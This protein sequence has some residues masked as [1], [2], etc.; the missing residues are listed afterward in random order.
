MTSYNGATPSWSGYTHQGKVGLITAL[1]EIEAL[2]DRTDSDHLAEE[3]SKWLLA[4]EGAEDFEITNDSDVVWSRHQVKAYPESM[5]QK[6]YNKVLL[7]HKNKA[8]DSVEGFDITNVRDGECYLHTVVAIN[9]WQDEGDTNPQKIKLYTYGTGDKYCDFSK[10]GDYDKLESLYQPL[11]KKIF[12]NANDNEIKG[13]W[14]SLGYVLDEHITEGHI[15]R[16]RPE[17][18]FYEIYEF[19]LSDNPLTKNTYHYLKLQIVGCWEERMRRKAQT[20]ALDTP[21]IERAR[22][23]FDNFCSLDQKSFFKAISIMHP[24]HLG[25]NRVDQIGID[26]VVY[27]GIEKINKDIDVNSMQ[28]VSDEKYILTA[29][30][31]DADHA[32]VYAEDICRK[33]IENPDITEQLFQNGNLITRHIEGSFHDLLAN[34]TQGNPLYSTSTLGGESVDH[35]M[36]PADL[37]F[38]KLDDVVAKYKLEVE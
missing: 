6:D 29:L 30:A 18:T 5:D 19:I 13:I 32:R 15:A 27:E 17:L 22:R 23:I 24:N 38:V 31:Q 11:I 21:A 20:E 28:L 36:N 3:L 1:Q 9:D 7:P 37:T 26:R 25:D 34:S 12:P 16:K 8:G 33:M 2:I 14:A 4:F 35:I 10:V